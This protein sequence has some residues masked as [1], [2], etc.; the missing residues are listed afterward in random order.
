VIFGRYKFI[1]LSRLVPDRS[2][3]EVDL[4]I[5]KKGGK[6]GCSNYRRISLLST[7]YKILS[8]ILPLRLSPYGDEIIADHQCNFRRNGSTTDQI[9]FICHTLEKKCEDRETVH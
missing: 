3:F 1:N 5:H 7:S 6:T 9:S 2:L 4:P 8:D